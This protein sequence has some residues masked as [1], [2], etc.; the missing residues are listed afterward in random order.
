M[1]GEERSSP[2]VSIVLIVAMLLMVIG[3][4]TCSPLRAKAHPLCVGTRTKLAYFPMDGDPEAMKASRRDW[5]T[6]RLLAMSEPSLACETQ[7]PVYRFLWLRSFHHPVTVRVEELPEG[8]RVVAVELDGTGGYQP[9]RES[10]RVDRM[11]SDKEVRTV[12]EALSEAN[13]WSAPDEQ[14]L[15]GFD[16]ARWVIEARD[17]KH[18]RIQ[19]VWSPAHGRIHSLGKA[20][21]ALTGWTIPKDELY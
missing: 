21:L 9:G 13:I 11:L 16:G 18:Y 10:R 14:D 15:H 5:Y 12:T 6:R 7:R 2:P 4:S 17:G 1:W 3:L 8:M 19:D 20:F